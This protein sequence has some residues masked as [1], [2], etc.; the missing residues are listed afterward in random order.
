MLLDSCGRRVD[1]LRLSITD[2][3]NRLRVTADGKAVTEKPEGHGYSVPGAP[4]FLPEPMS[5]VGG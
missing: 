1:S 3:C 4:P 2:R 5:R